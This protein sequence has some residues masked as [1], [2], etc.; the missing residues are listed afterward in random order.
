MSEFD[1][2]DDQRGHIPGDSALPDWLKSLPE[3]SRPYAALA[4]WD[5]PVG[6]WLLLLPCWM[7]LA[8]MRGLIDSKAVPADRIVIDQG[9]GMSRSRLKTV[10]DG[11]V[12]PSAKHGRG[13]ALE[14][15]VLSRS[16]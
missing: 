1:T 5:R 16:L 2:D 9:P 12:D 10:F 3:Q 7:G 11:P 14:G 13:L 4:R 6:I 15:E 8:L